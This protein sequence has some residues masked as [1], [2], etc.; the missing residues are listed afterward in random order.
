MHSWHWSVTCWAR[1]R[2]SI[3]ASW[4]SWIKWNRNRGGFF[5]YFI[6]RCSSSLQPFPHYLPCVVC[7]YYNDRAGGSGVAEAEVTFGILSLIHC[8]VMPWMSYSPWKKPI[9]FWMFARFWTFWNPQ[10]QCYEQFWEY[11]RTTCWTSVI[12]LFCAMWGS[13]LFIEDVASWQQFSLHVFMGS[14]QVTGDLP[15]PW[16]RWPVS[17]WGV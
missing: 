6:F 12:K 10:W 13:D 14:M 1:W 4:N 9:C 11:I 8:C 2:R 15:H 7:I 16:S 5:F 3:A 17:C